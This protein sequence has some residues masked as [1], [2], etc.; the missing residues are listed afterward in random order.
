MHDNLND[1]NAGVMHERK[2]T[3]V[4]RRDMERIV[5]LLLN[6]EQVQ[7]AHPVLIKVHRY[8]IL[9]TYFTK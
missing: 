7:G 2:I 5:K 8:Y 4:G 1:D 9:L 3:F 6:I